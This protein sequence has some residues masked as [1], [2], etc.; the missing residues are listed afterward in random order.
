MDPQNALKRQRNP[1]QKINN[2]GG[3]ARLYFK[4]YCRVIV[5]KTAW[6]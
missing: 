6:Y 2:I 3:L 1:K 4:L 5:I